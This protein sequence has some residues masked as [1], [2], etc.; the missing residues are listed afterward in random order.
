MAQTTFNPYLNTIG[1]QHFA[2]LQSI[3][4]ALIPLIP[5]ETL[6]TFLYNYIIGL[7]DYTPDQFNTNEIKSILPTA[8]NSY[9]N[10][11]FDNYSPEQLY[12]INLLLGSVIN[13]VPTNSIP[14]FILDIEDNISK[15]GL[16]AEQQVP[17]LFATAVGIRDYNYWLGRINTPVNNWYT[18]GYF[19]P[20]LNVN[21]SNLPYWVQASMQGTLT[22]ANKAKSYG[23]IDPPR[24]IGVDMVTALSGGI[25][26]A[27]GKVIYK[28][29]PRLQPVS[30]A[31]NLM[32]SREL[33]SAT[34]GGQG[35]G[36]V[37]RAKVICFSN[38]ESWICVCGGSPTRPT[39]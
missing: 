33:I 32:M 14:E 18:N 12:F 26:V 31:S 24:V 22:G 9:V 16:T 4:T 34:G 1:E 28:W 27:A 6:N 8:A 30:V 11:T 7:Y 17:L 15:S 39:A 5:F 3:E 2:G 35:G 10:P 13:D 20:N 21:L 23:L 37:F 38:S 25:G 19:D 29:V 36:G